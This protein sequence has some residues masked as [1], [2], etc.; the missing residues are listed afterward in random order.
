MR[1]W[2]NGLGEKQGDVFLTSTPL[3]TS[4]D[5]WF[6]NSATGTDAAAPAGKDR[7]APLATLRQASTNSADGDVILLESGHTE[8]ISARIDAKAVVIVGAGVAAGMPTVTLTP[9]AVDQGVGFRGSLNL[10]VGGELRNVR[11][12]A[13]TVSP[14]AAAFGYVT[15]ANVSRANVIGCWFDVGPLANASGFAGLLLVAGPARIEGCTFVST[16]TS[17]AATP[18]AGMTMSNSAS[19]V[20]IYGCTFDD[21]TFGFQTAALR[22]F[23]TTT[24]IRMVGCSFLRGADVITTNTVTGILAN[25]AQAGGGVAGF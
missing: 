6:V 16:A 1:Y 11:F 22:L 19:D 14:P 17:A 12:L 15:L 7:Q 20:E 9:N 10:P 25:Q 8:I 23:N 3:Y 2:P 18:Y 4:G 13:P 24:R 21:G 5:V